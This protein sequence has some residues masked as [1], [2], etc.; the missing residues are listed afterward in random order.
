MYYDLF[1]I[2]LSNLITRL[3]IIFNHL[4]PKCLTRKFIGIFKSFL[5]D[6]LFCFKVRS[7]LFKLKFPKFSIMIVKSK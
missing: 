4:G 3:C 7:V 6:L 1:L 2:F 5:S